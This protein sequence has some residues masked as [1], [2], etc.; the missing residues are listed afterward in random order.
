MI[1]DIAPQKLYNQYKKKT[2][3]AESRIC[4]FDRGSL[5]VGKTDAQ[6]PE[7]M[8]GL[9]FPRFC[10]FAQEIETEY[11][12]SIDE[13]DY[14]LAFG[15][16][17]A[18]LTETDAGGPGEPGSVGSGPLPDGF[19]FS[20]ILQLRDG[21]PQAGAEMFAAFTAFHLWKW[22]SANRFCGRCGH[23]MARGDEERVL[24]CPGCGNHIYPRLNPAVIVGVIN[25]DRILVTKY[26]T[27][28]AQSAL[29]AGFTE[30]GETFE[31]TVAR[32]VMEEAGIHV[33]NIRYYKSQPWAP[34]EDILAGFYCEVDGDDTIRMDTGE[35]KYAEWVKREDIVLQTTNYSLTN[36]ML[37]MFK[38]G[39]VT[40]P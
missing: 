25:G 19:E 13:T 11:L 3:S 17:G 28:Y 36:E 26:R 20:P 32:E 24:I 5:L 10:E 29:I 33:K 22:Y 14:F 18:P 12:F 31:Q 1:Q 23:P 9:R 35:L 34:A 7:T 40:E 21:R 6:D 8:Q 37:R 2:P 38:E 15:E 16:P 27:G 39:V 30:I 4:V